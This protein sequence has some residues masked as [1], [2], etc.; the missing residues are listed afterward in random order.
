MRERGPFPLRRRRGDPFQALTRAIVGQMLSTRAAATILA[1]VLAALD[2]PLAP[3]PVLRCGPERL[4]A[5]GLSR[6]KAAALLDLAR[7]V[8]GRTLDLPALIEAED[9][10]VHA[11]LTAIHGVGEW[12]AHM[13]LMFQLGR[14]DVFPS[15]DVGV[16]EGMRRA[17]RLRERP[18]PRQAEARAAAW[19]P[20]RSAGAWYMWQVLDPS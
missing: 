18:T 17:Y 10:A 11:A 3:G 6:V 19:A 4:R 8:D 5:A 12:T 20:F 1:R 15:K 14:P 16:L 7:R 9:A 2:G 13:F